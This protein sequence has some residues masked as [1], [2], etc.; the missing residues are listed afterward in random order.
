MPGCSLIFFAL[1]VPGANYDRNQLLAEQKRHGQ[2]PSFLALGH[3]NLKKSWREGRASNRRPDLPTALARHGLQF[4]DAYH[5]GLDDAR[6]I[7]R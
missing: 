6:N 5:R 7:A 4:E 2:A 3:I 1:V